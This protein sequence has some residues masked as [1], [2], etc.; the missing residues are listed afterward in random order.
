MSVMT[1]VQPVE[2]VRCSDADRE[3]TSARLRD[4]A[5]AGYLTMDETDERLTAAYA[6]RYGHELDALVH[7][8][9]RAKAFAGA[10]WPT[11]LS[12]VWMLLITGRR[13]RRLVIAA[14]AVV[15]VIGL[16]LGAFE[17]FDVFDGAEGADDSDDASE[18]ASDGDASDG[19]DD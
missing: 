3:R 17:A 6:A 18:D 13:H 15:A 5:A 1:Q 10:G 2:G 7:D 14:V 11:V 12:K 19:D 9:P 8:L 4:A 16:A